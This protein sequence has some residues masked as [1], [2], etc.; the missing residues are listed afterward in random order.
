MSGKPEEKRR[1]LEQRAFQTTRSLLRLFRAPRAERVPKNASRRP[2][3]VAFI[4]NE[5]RVHTGMHTGAAQINRLM[6]AARLA[7]RGSSRR[8]SSFSAGSATT[9]AHL[10]SRVSRAS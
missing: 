3:K 2:I 10:S 4:H 8:T 7:K 5:K 6:A 9:Y 1:G